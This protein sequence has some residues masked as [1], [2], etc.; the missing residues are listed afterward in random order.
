MEMAG[1]AGMNPSQGEA[2]TGGIFSL[3][4]SNLEG[5]K[6]NKILESVPGASDFVKKQESSERD[7]SGG[8]G[9]GGMLGG[10]MSS[11]GGGGS[12]GGGGA[13]GMAGLMA[14]LSGKG[15]D[16]GM[17]SKFLPQISSFLKEKSGTDVSS[18]L[19][20]PGGGGDASG[21]SSGGGAMS[22]LTGM[23]SGF[24]KK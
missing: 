11:I 21:G 2:A 6:F 4:K 14:S 20:V 19:G 1:K 12:G 13:G 24:M 10:A 18:V 22:S 7:A 23:A 17:M 8:G 15:I 5:D 16:S 9:M 3:L